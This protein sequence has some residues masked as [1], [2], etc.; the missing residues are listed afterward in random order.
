MPVTAEPQ[1]LRANSTSHEVGVD[2]EKEVI[3]GVIVAEEGPFKTPGRGEFD[4]M[5][6]RSIVKLMRE[7]RDGLKSRFAHPTLSEDGVGKFLGRFK[8]PSR[9]KIMRADPRDASKFLEREIVRADL[10]I[11]PTSHATPNGDLGKYVMDLAESDPD[12]FATSLVLQA[13][14]EWRLDKRKQPMIDE[15][16]GEELPPLWRPT[17]V[18]ALDVVDTGDATNGFLSSSIT[19]EGLPDEIVRRGTELLN[20]F[21][22]GESREVVS[23]R[24]ARWMN[25]YLDLRF[26]ADEEEPEPK[27]DAGGLLRR[28]LLKHRVA[29]H[30]EA[31]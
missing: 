11:D 15:E 6:L 24:L 12:A 21:L 10:H 22:P 23:A 7:K 16:T 27:V 14:H 25:R 2:R 9:Q 28:R 26:G 31:M 1:W 3:H 17:A 4:G 5:S 19:V 29:K 18:H 13:D 8:N 30:R 20:G